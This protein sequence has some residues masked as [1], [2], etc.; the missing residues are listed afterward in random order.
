MKQLQ[1]WWERA[2]Q[3][4]LGARERLP[5]MF[6]R[7]VRRTLLIVLAAQKRILLAL[8]RSRSLP[9]MSAVHAA[10][11]VPAVCAPCAVP[12]LHDLQVKSCVFA[13]L[14]VA[15]LHALPLGLVP[16][17]LAVLHALPVAHDV[18]V[19]AI[20]L[21][22]LAMTVLHV[23]HALPSVP[24]LW[25]VPALSVVPAVP[26]GVQPQPPKRCPA[27]GLADLHPAMLPG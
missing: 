21:T 13:L 26:D 22:L 9:A 24:V 14:S 5:A 2:W 6:A 10:P 7:P 23:A 8:W 18:L 12:V 16:T 27:I 15:A 20:L 19:I 3:V 4:G 17:L 1:L 25:A 11:A